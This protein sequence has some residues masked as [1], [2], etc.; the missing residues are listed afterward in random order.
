VGDGR[1]GR[2]HI[3]IAGAG[4]GGICAGIKL[5]QAGFEDFVILERS[6]RVGGTW[7]NNRYPGLCCDTPSLLYSFTFEQKV[8]WTRTCARQPE[9]RQYMQHCVDKYELAPHIRFNSDLR[10]A[11]WDDDACRW[12]LTTADGWATSSDVFIGA[13]GMF[14]Q[15]SWPEIP[16]LEDFGRQVIHT[17][18]W[19]EAGVDLRG[20]SVAVIGCAASATQAIPEIARDAA[21]LVVYLRTANWV[22]PKEDEPYSEARL[23]E[24]RLN[25]EI[26]LETRNEYLE[27][28]EAV[29]TFDKPELMKE[30][31]ENAFENLAAVDD[32]EIREQ[33]RPR[34][35]FGSQRIL[36]SNDFYPTFNRDNVELVTDEIESITPQG[37]TTVDGRERRVDVLILATGYQTTKF[38]SVIDVAGR[39]DVR[40]EDAWRDGAHAYLGITVSGFPNLFMLYGPNTNQG[41]ILLML[42]HEVDYIVRKLEHMR[43]NDIAWVDVRREAMDEYNAALQR[44]LD[45]V[46]VLQTIGTRYYRAASGRIVTQWPYTMAEYRARTTRPDQDAFEEQRAEHL[47]LGPV[48]R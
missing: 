4:P 42:E 47:S 35:P 29:L 44:H 31:E 39:G 22:V 26:G 3:T 12:L 41:S 43:Q 30:L 14:N 28:A 5:K 25:P 9:I 16:G 40:L 1:A 37:V 2:R 15:L 21:S 33:L 48:A 8:D 36:F 6:A 23:E 46:E 7:A 45:S 17:G 18:N 20:K 10:E 11:R 19:P 27:W 34:V 24:M 32:P 13:L 38:L